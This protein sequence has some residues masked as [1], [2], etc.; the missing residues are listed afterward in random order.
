MIYP[1]AL[2]IPAD[3][4]EPDAS[5]NKLEFADR[6]ATFTP[7]GVM[8]TGTID[9]GFKRAICRTTSPRRR[10]PTCP[11]SPIGEARPVHLHVRAASHLDAFAG[12]GFAHAQDRLWQ[13]EALLRRGTGRYA[14]WVG[15]SALA[16][17][18]LA[19]QL[20]T[21]GAS[22]RD[23]AL[24][25]TDTKAMLELMRAASTPSSRRARGRG[26]RHCRRQ[27]RGMGAVAFDRGNAPDRI[28]DGLGMVEAV[29]R[30]GV[31]DRRRG[32]H[33]ETAFR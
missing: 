1:V 18:V 27:A 29:A 16:G 26:I 13:M 14:Q 33:I 22:H 28:P 7:D 5:P 32:T 23:F 19:R 11:D 17:D 4:T 3:V 6:V 21:A 8:T 20:D 30:G 24:L 15:K 25:N 31:A 9:P 12:L 2:G 10:S